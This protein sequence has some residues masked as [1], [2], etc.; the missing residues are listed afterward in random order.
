[1]IER[2]LKITLFVWF[3]FL[4]FILFF[5]V[6]LLSDSFSNICD[7]FIWDR[8]NRCWI[9]SWFLN[10]IF[11]LTIVLFS[12]ILILFRSPCF[13]CVFSQIVFSP[14]R[15][16]PI[17]FWESKNDWDFI[18]YG[19][20]LQSQRVYFKLKLKLLKVS[21]LELISQFQ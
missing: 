8:L 4:F 18:F 7:W 3:I 14:I 10:I 20:I 9:D 15:I 17:N 13:A 16:E 11:A 6:L 2:I 21:I 1:M 19:T 12:L 5:R